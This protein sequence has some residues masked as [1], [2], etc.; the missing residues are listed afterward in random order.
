MTQNANPYG[1]YPSYA[2][3]NYFIG[4]ALDSGESLSV[5]KVLKLVYIAHGWHLAIYNSPLIQDEIQAWKYG[6]VIPA[7]YAKIKYKADF[8]SIIEVDGTPNLPFPEDY[9]FLG[10]IWEVYSKFTAGQ[11]STATHL[12]D[13]P[14]DQVWN[15]DDGKSK[16]EALISN[17]L[18]K[19]HYKAKL[20][21]N[22]AKESQESEESETSEE[23]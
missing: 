18:I 2:V 14:W 16:R 13:T 3:A 5:T 7:L 10:R 15:K 21:A 20:D 11:L 6:P 8:T 23:E 17:D 12:V 22:K 19:E 4:K 1:K 9:D